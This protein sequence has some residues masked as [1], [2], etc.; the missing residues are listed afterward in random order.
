VQD[1]QPLPITLPNFVRHPGGFRGM[2][3]TRDRLDEGAGQE[4]Q[5][6]A[7]CAPGRGAFTCSAYVPST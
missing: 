7:A 2:D 6:P 3:D 5:D 1:A 4:T